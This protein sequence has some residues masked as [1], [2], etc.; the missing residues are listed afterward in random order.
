MVSHVVSFSPLPLFFFLIKPK[1]CQ[2]GLVSV[3][4][5]QTFKPV[6]VEEQATC[7][8]V[9][10]LLSALSGDTRIVRSSGLS[11]FQAV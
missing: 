11:G 5:Q 10:S 1:T 4:F 3:S 8:S 9:L 7:C 6:W 2:I